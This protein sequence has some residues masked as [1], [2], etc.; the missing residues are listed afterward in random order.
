MERFTTTLRRIVRKIN[1]RPE[2][3][4]WGDA[5]ALPYTEGQAV[6]APGMI[7]PSAVANSDRAGA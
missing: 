2:V 3:E 7:G 6:L 5:R 1:R 4:Y